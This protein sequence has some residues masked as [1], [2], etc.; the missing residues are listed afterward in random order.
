MGQSFSEPVPHEPGLGYVGVVLRYKNKIRLIHAPDEVIRITRQVIEQINV[1]SGEGNAG[2]VYT[3]DKCG[4]TSMYLGPNCFDTLTGKTA[5]TS[6]K[7]F[8]VLMFEEMHKLGYELVVSTDLSREYDQATWIFVKRES[9]R[10]MGKVACLA[11]GRSDTL[12]LL[13]ADEQF[14]RIVKNSIAECWPFGIQAETVL[15]SCGESVTEIKLNGNPWKDSDGPEN[16]Y[17]RKMLL[18]IIAD[19][20]SVHYRL[21]AGTNLKGG[22]DSL[23]FIKD[24]SY[25][26]NITD[27]CMIGLTK[28]NKLQLFNCKPL[29]G[30]LRDTLKSSNENIESEEEN[31]GCWEFQLKGKPWCCVGDQA[32]TSRQLID[33][34]SE[35]ML[36]NGW[37]LTGA[38]TITR[39][40]NDKGVL[41]YKMA[42]PCKTDFACI[43]MADKHTIRFLDFPWAHTKA[44]KEVIECVCLPGIRREEEKGK[45]CCQIELNGSPWTFTESVSLHARSTLL[46]ILKKANSLGW[47]LAASADVSSKYFQEESGPDYPEDVHSW[48]FVYRQPESGSKTSTSGCLTGASLAVDLP[49]SY[50]DVVNNR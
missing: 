22:P 21:V 33:R 49:P 34:I 46:H 41:I 9:G 20:G 5:A 3:K 13:R 19:L 14:I 43:A 1:R 17:C 40:S 31:Y 27:L 47:E 32:N 24:D 8:T 15:E 35:T 12:V 10:R 30:P 23:F 42:P 18:S 37:A 39:C 50:E 2:N 38:I 45:A 25:T 4:T 7:M 6:G 11:P 28:K 16:I 44:L 26:T 36:A 29:S 48:Y